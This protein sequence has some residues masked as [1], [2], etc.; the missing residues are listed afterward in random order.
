MS[1]RILHIIKSLASFRIKCV[2]D[3]ITHGG[4]YQYLCATWR[5][6]FVDISTH[7]SQS[8]PNSSPRYLHLIHQ[9]LVRHSKFTIVLTHFD[10]LS[11]LFHEIRKLTLRFTNGCPSPCTIPTQLHFSSITTSPSSF[12]WM[13]D[14]MVQFW[15]YCDWVAIL[16]VDRTL[17]AWFQSVVATTR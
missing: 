3:H 16:S 6:W 2:N 1:Y 14:N 13:N 15:N 12:G 11:S 10:S 8:L 4:W 17:G 9:E 7:T 5:R